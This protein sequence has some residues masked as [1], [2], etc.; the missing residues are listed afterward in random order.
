MLKNYTSTVPAAKSI[1]YIESRLAQFD[2][3]KVVRA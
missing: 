3:R 1:A 2:P